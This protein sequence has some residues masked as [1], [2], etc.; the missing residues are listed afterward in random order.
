MKTSRIK[1]RLFLLHFRL[2]INEKFHAAERLLD[3][4]RGAS[5]TLGCYN[6][7]ESDL[8]DQLSALG[9]PYHLSYRTGAATFYAPDLAQD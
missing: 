6:D 2:V 3:L 7:Q 8:Y 4:I 5:I 9:L 1:T